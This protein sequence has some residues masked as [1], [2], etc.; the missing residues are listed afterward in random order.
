MSIFT[1]KIIACAAMALSHFG[2]VFMGV[3]PFSVAQG[4]Y[5]AG[6]ISFPIFAYLL[7]QGWNNTKYKKRYLRNLIL[8]AL[9]SRIPF[10]L[11]QYNTI[12]PVSFNVLFTLF[13]GALCL[14]AI[15][16]VRAGDSRAL[17]LVPAVVCLA[18]CIQLDFGWLGVLT[19]SVMGL[20]RL[21]YIR[22]GILTA[23]MAIIYLQR[24]G[25]LF[26][27]LSFLSTLPGIV[28]LLFLNPQKP[29]IRAKYFFYAFYPTHLLLL[30]VL[31]LDF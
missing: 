18:A 25:S 31:S 29:C 16:R 10:T 21:S 17:F 12:A 5:L 14:W 8:F 20:F 24:G 23:G 19:I 6:R 1:L 27:I 15:D 11:A 3:I 4:F 30:Y 9:L 13:L 28:M 2:S 22:I 26:T 7:V